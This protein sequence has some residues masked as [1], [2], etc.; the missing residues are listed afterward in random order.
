[1]I[2]Y[3]GGHY[4]IDAWIDSSEVIIV[5]NMFALKNRLPLFVRGKADRI[6]RI[7]G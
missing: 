3:K 7:T 5:I 1:M 2:I 6:V 4:Y